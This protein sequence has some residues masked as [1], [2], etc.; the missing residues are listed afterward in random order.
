MQHDNITN[1][2][3]EIDYR[4]TRVNINILVAE[5]MRTW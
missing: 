4:T 5:S 1:S 2:L 3:I